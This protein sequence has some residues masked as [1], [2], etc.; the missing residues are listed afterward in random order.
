MRPPTSGSPQRLI[1]LHGFTQSARIWDPVRAALEPRE[2]VALDLPGHGAGS[3]EG[4]SLAEGADR[5]AE[6][7]GTGTW[8]GYSMGERYALH[9]ALAHPG[10]VG[11][12]V[13][14]GAH[15]GLEDD[16]ERAR[17]RAADEA[18]ATRIVSVG[19]PT[20]LEEWLAQPLFAGLSA[21]ARAP[22]A[23][24][25]NRA[26]GLARALRDAGTGTQEPL[27]NR[28][29]DL[30]MPVLYVVGERDGRYRAV[31][32]RVVE[33]LGARGRLAVVPDAGHAAPFEQPDAFVTLLV[34][35]LR[36]TAAPPP[37]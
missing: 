7:G 33:A 6:R 28:L 12:L 23:R 14:V 30:A 16:A 19:L 32:E 11:G 9:V 3:D 34:R 24:R 25:G 36:E 15:P 22:E 26:A 31:G 10:R 5:L 35:W 13:L 1:L 29:P 4:G 21:A 37:S 20:F 2:S 27:W 17:R 8:V 18:L